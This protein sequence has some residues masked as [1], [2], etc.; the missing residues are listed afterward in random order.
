LQRYGL[1]VVSLRNPAAAYL[2]PHYV[3]LEA[4]E[5]IVKEGTYAQFEAWLEEVCTSEK[6]GSDIVAYNFGLFEGEN[7]Y[8]T[9]LIGSTEYDE[10]DPDWACNGDFVPKR[11]YFE[12]SGSADADWQEIQTIVEAFVKQFISAPDCQASF[13]STAQAITVGFDDGDLVKVN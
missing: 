10:E 2:A 7:G 5:M 3:S 4:V 9:Y 12:L 1:W 13:L 11:K 6:P 8:V